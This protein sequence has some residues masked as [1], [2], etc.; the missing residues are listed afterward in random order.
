MIAYATDLGI[1]F[2]DMAAVWALFEGVADG[3]DAKAPTLQVVVLTHLQRI[4]GDTNC[5][6]ILV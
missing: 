4:F 5:K 1:C 6:R 2:L 3:F